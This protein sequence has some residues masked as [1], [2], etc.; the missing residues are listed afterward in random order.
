LQISCLKN[1]SL[2]GLDSE[3]GDQ[4]LHGPLLQSKEITR[5]SRSVGPGINA[6]LVQAG[7]H[8]WRIND[9]VDVGIDFVDDRRR[10][11]RWDNDLKPANGF[12]AG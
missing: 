8:V 9:A 7:H 5:S 3:V 1:G 4:L 11:A 12:E 2:L 6:H 10:G